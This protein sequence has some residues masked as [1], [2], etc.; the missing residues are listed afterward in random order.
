M[1]NLQ[2]CA[3]QSQGNLAECYAAFFLLFAVLEFNQSIS[4]VPMNGLGTWYALCSHQAISL[5]LQP[6][7][8]LCLARQHGSELQVSSCSSIT[9]IAFLCSR[10]ASHIFQDVWVWKQLACPGYCILL[11]VLDALRNACA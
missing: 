4:S 5:N 3:L 8:I 2:T 6:G 7:M 11:N 9:R 1:P 10:E